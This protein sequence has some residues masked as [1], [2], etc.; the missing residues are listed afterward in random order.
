M[1][2][3]KGERGEAVRLFRR[4][5]DWKVRF[6]ERTLDESQFGEFQL[7]GRGCPNYML[8]TPQKGV[9]ENE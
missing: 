9:S 7:W 3:R 4:R 6:G 5:D 2:R 1:K 8:L